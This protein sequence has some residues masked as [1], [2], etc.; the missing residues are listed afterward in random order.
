MDNKI[1][2][3]FHLE[4]PTS[5]CL[6]NRSALCIPLAYSF[7]SLADLQTAISTLLQPFDCYGICFI[8]PLIDVWDTVSL[9]ICNPME[10][11]SLAVT[12]S[13]RRAVVSNVIF[14]ATGDFYEPDSNVVQ[15]ICEVVAKEFANLSATLLSSNARSKHPIAPFIELLTK[16]SAIADDSALHRFVQRMIFLDTMKSVKKDTGEIL[17]TKS[18]SRLNELRGGLK[19]IGWSAE[20]IA[21]VVED[22]T[23]VVKMARL[24]RIDQACKNMDLPTYSQF[25]NSRQCA[26][27]KPR[28]E[29]FR[30]IATFLP[31]ELTRQRISDLLWDFFDYFLA[32]TVK[33]IVDLVLVIRHDRKNSTFLRYEILRSQQDGSVVVANVFP[34]LSCAMKPKIT[35][36]EV[37]EICR[38]FCMNRLQANKT[39]G[40]FFRPIM[41]YL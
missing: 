12:T 24:A 6:I 37:R 21:N 41:F 31:Q 5:G 35:T 38:I 25:C 4:F 40:M 17:A 3:Y 18:R 8:D 28:K 11:L 22:S 16:S 1:H 19:E 39:D 36:H 27:A 34:V 9:Q 32:D 14:A 15:L 29:L 20:Q 13:D 26:T 7:R 30:V 23:G 33:V 2:L 10:D